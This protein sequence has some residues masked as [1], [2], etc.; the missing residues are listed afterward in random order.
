MERKPKVVGIHR[1]VMKA[2]SDNFRASSVQGVM[3]RI[4]AKGITVIVFE[5]SLEANTFYN[6]EVVKEET[7]FFRR[8]DTIV[9]NRM[10]KNLKAIKDKVVTRDLFENN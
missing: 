3:K 1:L 10:T 4:K 9:A 6:S 7:E 2:G 5:P 8:S